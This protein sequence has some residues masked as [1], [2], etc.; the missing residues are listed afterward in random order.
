M[1]VKLMIFGSCVSRDTLRFDDHG[2][3]ELVDYYARSSL[4][5]LFSP[6]PPPE[7][8]NNDALNRIC[9]SFQRRVVRRDMEKSFLV[10]GKKFDVLLMDFI[11]ER[12]S[13]CCYGKSYVTYSTEYRK[14]LGEEKVRLLGAFSDRKLELWYQAFD[15]FCE[16][17]DCPDVLKI[18][19]VYWTNR[20]S[21][22]ELIDRVPL[23]RIERANSILDEM[24]RYA[25]QKLGDSCFINYDPE[26]LF[27]DIDHK[28]GVS[29][30]H[31]NEGLYRETL[32]RICN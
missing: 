19:K 27:C 28:W 15:R 11:D 22:G 16:M 25:E 20:L 6:P 24:Y 12:F 4:V 17:L 31:Y 29:P 5:S 7:V 21:N 32:A 3:I 1:C 14:A 13:L 2:K 18:N 26:L 10:H 9:S 23:E 8:L 30:F